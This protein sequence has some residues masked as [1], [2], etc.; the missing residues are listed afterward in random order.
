MMQQ[1]RFSALPYLEPGERLVWEGAPDTGRY[2][3]GR[4]IGEAISSY[5][6]L[7]V[8][9]AFLTFLAFLAHSVGFL[10]FAG[11]LFAF[12]VLVSILSI[13][14]SLS[15]VSSIQNA[16]YAITDRRVI[17]ISGAMPG[18]V[19]KK[20]TSHYADRIRY[21]RLDSKGVL[22]DGWGNVRVGAITSFGPLPQLRYYTLAGV[23]NPAQVA[24][25]IRAL[26]EGRLMMPTQVPVS[27]QVYPA[28][29]PYP[30]GASPQPPYP[31]Y[32]GNPYPY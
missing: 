25:L 28:P 11:A 26:K 18:V 1:H 22:T 30:S 27:G 10:I 19:P 21:V 31:N 23:P 7:M 2:V 4:L 24:E 8:F 29:Y 5:I 14:A 12:I 20:I 13:P 9:T 16:H 15:Q 32:P 17:L 6:L 3:K